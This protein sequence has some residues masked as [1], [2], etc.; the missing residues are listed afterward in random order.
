LCRKEDFELGN[1][2]NNKNVGRKQLGRRILLL[3]LLLRKTTDL[4]GKLTHRLCKNQSV[5]NKNQSAKNKNNIR[6]NILLLLRW[7]RRQRPMTRLILL[8]WKMTGV[9]WKLTGRLWKNQSA[10]NKNKVRVG[11]NQSAKNKNNILKNVVKL[12]L[13]LRWLRRQRPKMPGILW[14]L[15]RHLYLLRKL[16]HRLCKNQSAKN[17]NNIRKNILLLR[18]KRPMTR[19]IPLL[20]KMV[21]CGS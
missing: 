3:L 2:T 6:K 4:L 14:R 10:K 18:R 13:L 15:T 17:K 9:L 19:L 7:L 8:L 16:T 12:L 1:P 20:W 5:K 21:S 11:E